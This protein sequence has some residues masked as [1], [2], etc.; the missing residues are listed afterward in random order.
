MEQ[1]SDIFH[2]SLGNGRK[3][4]AMASLKMGVI[5]EKSQIFRV[6]QVRFIVPPLSA[7]HGKGRILETLCDCFGVVSGTG[8]RMGPRGPEAPKQADL[9]QGVRRPGNRTSFDYLRL[10]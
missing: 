10:Q 3:P 5:M 6:S 4:L 2:F 7:K 9:S 1:Q 8:N